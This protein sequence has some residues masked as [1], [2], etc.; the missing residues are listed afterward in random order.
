MHKVGEKFSHAL[1]DNAAVSG[2]TT[3]KTVVPSL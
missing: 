1:H 2:K 3:D